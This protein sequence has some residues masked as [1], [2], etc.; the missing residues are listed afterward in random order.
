[1]TGV[2]TCALPICFP[3]TIGV[4]IIALQYFAIRQAG[5]VSEMV[6]RMDVMWYPTFNIGY[7]IGVDGISVAMILLTAIVVF[8]P[9]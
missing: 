4:V 9:S 5:D 1:M 8:A 3:V 2:Q 6:M 7:S